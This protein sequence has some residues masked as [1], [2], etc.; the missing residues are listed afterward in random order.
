MGF[1][2]SSITFVLQG[3][4]KQTIERYQ[5]YAY[6]K[7]NNENEVISINKDIVITNLVALS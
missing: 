1:T 2:K 7:I 5:V 4:I 6:K 3:Q